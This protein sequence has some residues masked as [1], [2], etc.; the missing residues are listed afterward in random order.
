M[1]DPFNEEVSPDPRV[2]D[3]ERIFGAISAALRGLPE[4][5][6]YP[7]YD[8]E[9][10]VALPRLREGDLEVSF[11]RNFEAVHGKVMPDWAA[12]RSFLESKGARG[13][14]VDPLLLEAAQAGL[15]EGFDLRSDWGESGMMEADF[16]IT[17]GSGAIAESGTVILK[18][19][20]TYRRLAAL[21]PWVHIALVPRGSLVRSVG[22]ALAGFD[23]D[24]NII[25]VTGPSKTADV[26]GILIEGVHGPGE[27]LCLFTD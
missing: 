20:E 1:T 16:G 19:R 7:D 24:P 11:R 22:E 14:A 23:D 10:M 2:S 26:E 18:D 3:R 27:Q 9:Q 25:F 12:I 13:G 15:G 5:A 17:R 21:A 4:R 6:P 8:M